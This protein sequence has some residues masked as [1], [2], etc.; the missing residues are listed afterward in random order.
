MNVFC[1]SLS[2]SVGSLSAVIVDYREAAAQYGDIGVL[3]YFRNQQQA[4]N[5]TPVCGL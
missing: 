2:S 3:K 5:W 1:F 4:V